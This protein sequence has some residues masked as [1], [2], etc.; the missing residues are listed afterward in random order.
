MGA[1]GCRPCSRP[2][3]CCPAAASSSPAADPCCSPSPP[4][5]PPP[6]RRCRPSSRPPAIC[7]TPATP[8]ARHQPGQG[9]RS[10]A[11]RS[12]TPEAPGP[13][14]AAQRR[15]RGPRHRP[16]RGRH[17]HP[18]GRRLASRTGTGRR[19]ACDALAVGHGLVP[20]SS[21]PRRPA[22][23]PGRC[24]TEP[25]GSPWTASRRPRRPGCG[26]PAR[27]GSG[28]RGTRPHRGRAGRT[29]DRRAAPRPPPR[30]GPDR[31]TAPPPGPHA[32]LRRR[33]GRAHA[34][35]PGWPRWL[36]DDTDVCRCEEVSAGRV[37]EAVTELGARDARTV[38]LLTRAG[39]GWCQGRMCGTAVACLAAR[40][41]AAEPPAERRPFA[42]PVRLSTL[43]ALDAPDEEPAGPD[44]DAS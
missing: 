16:G 41:A 28:R 35:G 20:R 37:R 26:R 14:P 42:V 18:A 39:M 11:A 1:G 24:P 43:A 15:H 44:P 33:H 7:G 10:P 36:T 30:R 6:A 21:W 17:R 3:S 5:S 8:G 25:W 34:P 23:P 29:G 27:P 38:K 4:P 40:G 22:A 31:R 19:I 32:R 9:G 2:A 13:R 12:R